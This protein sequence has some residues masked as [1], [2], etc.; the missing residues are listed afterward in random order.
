MRGLPVASVERRTALPPLARPLC[1]VGSEV[2]E[3]E[4]VV[5]EVREEARPA[6]RPDSLSPSW[7]VE[8]LALLAATAFRSPTWEVSVVAQAVQEPVLLAEVLGVSV[9]AVVVVAVILSCPQVLAVTA[10]TAP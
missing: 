4:A 7:Q 2:E 3:A 1:M 5:L 9:L 8:A 10:V 6:L